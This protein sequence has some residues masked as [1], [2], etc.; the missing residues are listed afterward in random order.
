MCLGLDTKRAE[1]KVTV[2]KASER[3]SEMFYE[4]QGK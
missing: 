1:Q 3:I 4:K 2:N